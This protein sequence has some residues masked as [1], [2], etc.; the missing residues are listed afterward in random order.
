MQ[1]SG[2]SP[3][4]PQKDQISKVVLLPC[5]PLIF[6]TPR[7]FVHLSGLVRLATIKIAP[8][9]MSLTI[10][11][12]VCVRPLLLLLL[13]SI[14]GVVSYIIPMYP[15]YIPY[16]APIHLYMSPYMS[17]HNPILLSELHMGH[18]LFLL[19]V[20]HI[21]SRCMLVSAW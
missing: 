18:A 1:D 5:P 13:C 16:V 3:E 12:F 7:C 21:Y 17:L 2:H 15:K 10:I 11:I 9:C 14:I 20:R 19:E 8:G 6:V 4:C